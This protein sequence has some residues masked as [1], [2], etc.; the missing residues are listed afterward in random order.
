MF[1]LLQLHS[2]LAS[3]EMSVYKEYLSVIKTVMLCV[4]IV[5]YLLRCILMDVV[6]I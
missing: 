4:T 3:F 6:L 2:S 1:S 5:L